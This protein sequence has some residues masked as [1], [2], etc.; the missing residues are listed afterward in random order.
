[1]HYQYS[2]VANEV[3]QRLNYCDLEQTCYSYEGEPPSEDPHA[4]V[5]KQFLVDRGGE[6]EVAALAEERERDPYQKEP[7]AFDY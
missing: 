1:M 6:R 2:V 7:F 5:A 3:E 4:L